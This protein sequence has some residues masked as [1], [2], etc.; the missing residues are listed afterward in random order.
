[1]SQSLKVAELQELTLV[2]GAEMVSDQ[3]ISV[4]SLHRASIKTLRLVNKD[5][6]EKEINS[7]TQ[8]L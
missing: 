4:I 6:Q 7:I 3:Q 5:I 1:M 8:L 2:V